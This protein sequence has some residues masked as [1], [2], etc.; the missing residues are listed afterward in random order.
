MEKGKVDYSTKNIYQKIQMVKESILKENLKKS[1]ENKYAGFK[2]YELADF[3]PSIIKLCNEVGLFTKITFSEELATLRIVNVN[4]PEEFEEY[5]SPMRNLVLKGCNE[6]QA[7]GGVETYSRRYL[8]MSA[9]DIIE[10]DMFDAKSENDE[11][12][13]S[14]ATPK[15]IEI[16]EK[17]YT[18]ETR[19]KLL[20]ANNIDKLEDLSVKKASELIKKLKERSV[21]NG[22]S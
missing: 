14:K 21:E 18:G 19:E 13:E 12:V 8:Y 9:F 2:Y 1:G 7:L 16:L 17:V 20:K 5:T 4:K 3:T 6:I 22:N 11:V 15:Q 10:N